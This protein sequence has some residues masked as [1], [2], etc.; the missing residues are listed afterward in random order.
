VR[1]WPRTEGF[2]TIGRAFKRRVKKSGSNMGK[3]KGWYRY[4]WIAELTQRPIPA[5][6]KKNGGRGPPKSGRQK[7]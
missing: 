2:T 6:A 4:W 5:N 7:N 3:K 1:Y